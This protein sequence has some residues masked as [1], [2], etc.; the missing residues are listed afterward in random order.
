MKFSSCLQWHPWGSHLHQD[1]KHIMRFVTCVR[2]AAEH[3][4]AV[5]WALTTISGQEGTVCW[6]IRPVFSPRCRPCCVF[7]GV[8]SS[9]KGERSRT[10]WLI[11]SSMLSVQGRWFQ[12][13]GRPCAE[14][15][16]KER[17]QSRSQRSCWPLFRPRAFFN[18]C[19]LREVCLIM[20]R[21]WACL[22]TVRRSNGPS[23]GTVTGRDRTVS[24]AYFPGGTSGKHSALWEIVQFLIIW[25]LAENTLAI[26]SWG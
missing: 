14:E 20:E 23:R 3:P 19:L 11:K 15:F 1:T 26:F 17:A 16:L 2:K 9:D 25:M 12:I 5:D 10:H 21:P 7:W 8:Q 4:S 22:A 6:S 13:G 24:P 18:P